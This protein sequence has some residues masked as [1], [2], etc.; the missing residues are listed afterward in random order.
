MTFVLIHGGGH[1]ARC[2]E[3]MLPF[4]RA[5]ATAVDLPG[6]GSRPGPLHELRIA[7]W[8]DSVVADLEALD[9]PDIVLVGHSMAGL[10][11]PGVLER[12]H[13]RIRHVVFVSCVILPP[14][15]S[16]LDRL[17]RE[18]AD[19]AAA[20]PPSPLGSRLSPAEL[21]ANQC[22][23]MDD[24]QTEFTLEVVVPEAYWPTREHVD[25][26][27]LDRPV[28]RTWVK[29]LQDRTFPPAVQDEMAQRA[30]CDHVVELRSPHL[31]M[32]SHAAELASILDVIHDAAVGIAR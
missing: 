19:R 12:A 9:D 10:T 17:P 30:G 7:D 18:L 32:I 31:A 22:A 11:I 8:V 5:P 6:R 1:S 14:E 15:S 25:P 24:A 26:S 23:D 16:L 3:P 20:I 4:L 28:P 13:E 2:W 29:L 27:G 21:R